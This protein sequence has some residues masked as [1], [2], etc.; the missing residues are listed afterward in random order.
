MCPVVSGE[1]TMVNGNSIAMILRVFG[2]D[3]MWF[4]ESSVAT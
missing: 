2:F 3:L 4:G 1:Q